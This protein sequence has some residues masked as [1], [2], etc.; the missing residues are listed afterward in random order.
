VAEVRWQ[1]QPPHSPWVDDRDM[2]ALFVQGGYDHLNWATVLVDLSLD[3]ET[4][5]RDLNR[6]AR[7]CVNKCAR[8][9]VTVRRI[10]DLDDFRTS[11]FEPYRTSETAYGR[12]V[13]PL[14]VFEAMFEADASGRYDYFIALDDEQRTIS[15]L[16][17]H[18]FGGLATEIAST[19]VPAAREK[20]LPAQDLL[21]W[22][23]I[24]WAKGE[25]CRYFDL[26]GVN[27]QPRNRA[28]AGI[29][30]FKEK[31]GG[32]LVIFDRFHKKGPVGRLAARVKAWK[33]RRD[34]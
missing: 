7:K 23:L 8:Q 20:G 10:R 11:F 9:G 28:E 31:W 24:R 2:A 33:N 30:R 12:K 21:H 15:T 16:G 34:E 32:R 25:G 1:G 19:L 18:T 5:W 3:M 6:A 26:A 14:A 13:N 4:L 29:R 27:P 22:E 17:V